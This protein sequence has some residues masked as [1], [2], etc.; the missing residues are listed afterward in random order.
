V[1]NET[2]EGELCMSHPF[3]VGKTYR[4][5]HGEYVVQ[6]IEGDRM[7]IRYVG[8]G[9]LE[10]R[11]GIQARIWENIQ[12]EKQMARAEERRQLAR[13]ARLEARRRAA[14][15]RRAAARP[16]FS[17]FEED[18]FEV[19]SRGLA[20]KGRKELGRVLAYELEQKTKKSYGYWIV[21]RQSRVHIA[22][23][24]QYDRE[25]RN[26]NAAFFVAAGERGVT[27]GFRISKPEGK[28]KAD[29]AWPT[30]LNHLLAEEGTRQALHAAMKE[31][32]LSLDV[33]AM[34][35]S[36]GQIAR[37]KAQDDGFLW[38][39]ETAEQEVHREM[40]GQE[41][42]DYLQTVAPEKRSAL[43]VRKR[44]APEA[45]I[46]GGAGIA[47]ELAGVLEAL[48]PLLEASIPA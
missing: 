36:Y 6:A 46:Q 4:N 8:G 29:W 16:K 22:L 41:L 33:Y 2:A 10:T 13:E 25:T 7:K 43:F 3:E 35:V 1:G 19:L 28:A 45:A 24:E 14:K 21:P 23:K 39:Q 32:E 47:K 44:L 37:V 38:Q 18:N 31:H 30:L 26:R 42:A 11:V 15:A 5:R 9:T 17:G 48:V 40:D 20:W 27:Y 34:Q 12:F